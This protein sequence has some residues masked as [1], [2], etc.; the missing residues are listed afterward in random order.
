MKSWKVFYQTSWRIHLENSTSVSESG[1]Q[2]RVV[3]KIKNP[4]VCF[5]FLSVLAA[6]MILPC[7]VSAGST[8]LN[9]FTPDDLVVTR[10][11]RI[12]VVCGGIDEHTI[13]ISCLVNGKPVDEIV[14]HEDF[15]HASAPLMIGPNEIVLKTGAGNETTDKRTV[16]REILGSGKSVEFDFPAYTFHKQTR[17]ACLRCHEMSI[18]EKNNIRSVMNLCLQCHTELL[19]YGNVHGPI[20]V[21]GCFSCHPSDFSD[22]DEGNNLLDEE[23]CFSCHTDAAEYAQR[24]F[25]HGPLNVGACTSCHNPHAA[26]FPFSLNYPIP[27]LCFF[28]HDTFYDAS[29]GGSAHSPAADGDCIICHDPHGSESGF[30]LK[31]GGVPRLCISC[32]NENM[33]NHTHPYEGKPGR[34]IKL[35]PNI[36]LDSEGNWTCTSCHNPHASES[37]HL[38]VTDRERTCTQC[39]TSK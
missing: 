22:T 14:R 6:G 9:W 13:P 19:D 38:L 37:R 32:H 39:H 25:L 36:L 10:S 17:E 11:A 5:L 8:N 24:D 15:L 27:D 4:F 28:C 31:K 2:E 23:L 12:W 21:G 30:S 26:D 29:D 3:L 18:S 20:N 1:L 16:F 34:R 35:P 7:P 33:K